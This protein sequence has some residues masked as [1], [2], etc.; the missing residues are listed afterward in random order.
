M[1]VTRTKERRKSQTV[2]KKGDTSKQRPSTKGVSE[3]V[4]NCLADNCFADAVVMAIRE[5]AKAA[6]LPHEHITVTVREPLTIE[7]GVLVQ[8]MVIAESART[9]SSTETLKVNFPIRH[10]QFLRTPPTAT[11]SVGGCAKF[12]ARPNRHAPRRWA[13]PIAQSA[14]PPTELD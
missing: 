6:D 14:R 1:Q 13:G 8:Q 9:K 7:A 10:I 12:V 4:A 2:S 11:P 3:P 5:V